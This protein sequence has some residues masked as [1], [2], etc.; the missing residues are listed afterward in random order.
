M[1]LPRWRKIG[2]DMQMT[3]EGTQHDGV[4]GKIRFYIHSIVLM[5][6]GEGMLAT[7]VDESGY[8]R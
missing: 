4:L 8:P 6:A 5:L 7:M 3:L 2:A 1:S